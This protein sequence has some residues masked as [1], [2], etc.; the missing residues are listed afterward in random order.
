MVNPS[1]RPTAHADNRATSLL[2]HTL[3]SEMPGVIVAISCLLVWPAEVGFSAR[4]SA[5]SDR[6]PT[7]SNDI[8]LG[9]WNVQ[10]DTVGLLGGGSK[11]SSVFRHVNQ[12]A[13]GLLRLP[14]IRR[15]SV[16]RPA[17]MQAL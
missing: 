15:S 3:F 8:A 16:R 9:H 11:P 13:I 2:V 14:F 10:F 7:A 12:Y 5:C 17:S 1:L 4:L 6:A